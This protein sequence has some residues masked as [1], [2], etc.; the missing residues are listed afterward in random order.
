MLHVQVTKTEIAYK[1]IGLESD[2]ISARKQYCRFTKYTVLLL[3]TKPGLVQSKFHGIILMLH[4]GLRP[5]D[6]SRPIVN[7]YRATTYYAQQAV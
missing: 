5:R 7:C 4:A 6:T 1:G 2:D 3:C